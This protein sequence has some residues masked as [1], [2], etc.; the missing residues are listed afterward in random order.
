LMAEKMG[1]KIRQAK[2]KAQENNV[3]LNHE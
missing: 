1:D 3:E 2:Q